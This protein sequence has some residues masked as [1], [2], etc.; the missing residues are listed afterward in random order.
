MMINI[1]IIPE[2]FTVKAHPALFEIM[3]AKMMFQEH[4]VEGVLS[5]LKRRSNLLLINKF[6]TLHN[7]LGGS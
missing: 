2:Q 6:T 7:F 3:K 1:I 5:G 4:W